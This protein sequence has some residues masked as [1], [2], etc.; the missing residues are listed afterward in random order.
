LS[1][2]FRQGSRIS[3]IIRAAKLEARQFFF[4][5]FKETPSQEEQKTIHF[6]RLKHLYDGFLN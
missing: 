4:L 6:Q 1:S 3:K 2:K 5:N